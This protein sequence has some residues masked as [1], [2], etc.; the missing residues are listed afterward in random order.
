MNVVVTGGSGRIGTFVIQELLTHGHQVTNLDASAPAE[1]RGRFLRADLTDLGQTYGG[2]AGADAVIHLAAIPHPLSDP[3]EVVFRNN[4]LSTY[5]VLEAANTLGIR[6]VILTSSFSALGFPF[7]RHVMTPEYIPMDEDHPLWPQDAYG[8]SKQIGEIMA[9]SFVRR[10]PAMTIISLRPS[11]VIVP[12]EYERFLQ[13]AWADPAWGRSTFWT[14]TDVRD[15][16]AAFR[17][18]L[19]APLT[20]HHPFFIMAPNTYMKDTPTD[21]LLR[22]YYPEIPR[23]EV[24]G[25][26]A[27]V[28]CQRAERLLGWHAQHTWEMYVH[29][30]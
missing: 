22:R 14:Y 20:G 2:L 5:N 8:L 26:Q 27:P 17:L 11:A 24:T 29:G 3:P 10:T 1:P 19:T 28:S 12:D 15:L 9:E 7:A 4:V 30:S 6:R 18:A 21:E 13:R 16:A 23:V 25:M